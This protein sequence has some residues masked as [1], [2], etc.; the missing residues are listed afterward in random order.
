[1]ASFET[2]IYTET[3]KTAIHSMKREICID[4]D[5]NICTDVEEPESKNLLKA[6]V[7]NIDSM[8]IGLIK[9][10]EV[11]HLKRNIIGLLSSSLCLFL[12]YVVNSPLLFLIAIAFLLGYTGM[13]LT[14]LFDI[15]IKD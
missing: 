3:L 15:F 6:E 8:K 7:E 12:F 4:E 11:I 1:M 2:A 14:I 10:Y 13:V 9:T 5:Y